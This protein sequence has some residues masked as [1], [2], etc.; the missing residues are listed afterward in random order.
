MR[1]IS[2]EEAVR[3]VKSAAG[4]DS[5]RRRALAL[6][7]LRE[8]VSY[9]RENSPLLAE[10]YKDLPENFALRDLPILDKADLQRGFDDW[11]TDREVT[12]A[13]LTRHI[14]E[15]QASGEQRPFLGRYTVIS[16]SGSTGTPFTMLRDEY[17]NQ[18]HGALVAQ[19]LMERCPEAFSP[20]KNRIA[21]VI[22][23]KPGVSSY[24][25]FLRAQKAAGEYGKNMLA[26]GISRPV[27]EIVGALNSFAPTSLTGY[28][29]VLTALAKEQNEG[30]LHLALKCV[31]SSAEMLSGKAFDYITGAFKCPVVNNYCMTEGGEIAMS[32]GSCPNLHVND[33]WILVEPVD[34]EGNPTPA[35]TYSDGALITDL[36]NYICPIIRYKVSDRI[37]LET[38]PCACASNFPVMRIAGRVANCFTLRGVMFFP[39]GLT[40]DLATLDGVVDFQIARVAADAME[41]RLSVD[42]KF[43]FDKVARDA[44]SIAYRQLSLCGIDAAKVRVSRQIGANSEKTGK[45]LVVIDEVKNDV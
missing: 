43:D 19:R 10:K 40:D 44:E 31:A 24:S 25:S 30:R 3:L 34:R 4:M 38:S 11:V 12:I 14:R 17:H 18:I 27:R 41:V 28:P 21:S 6:E 29:S 16:T 39:Y 32:D 22:I 1:R 42:G 36:S 2:W 26:I 9:A 37:L 20:M 45:R 7:R 23:A 8:L 5:D 15:D 35:G 33:D 13:A